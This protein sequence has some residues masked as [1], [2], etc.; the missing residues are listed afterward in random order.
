MSSCIT[1]VVQFHSLFQS[2]TN[3]GSDH[4]SL[5]TYN[6]EMLILSHIRFHAMAS[7]FPSTQRRPEFNALITLLSLRNGRQLEPELDS[8]SIGDHSPTM[9]FSNAIFQRPNLRSNSSSTSNHLKERFLDRL[10]EVISNRKGVEYVTCTVMTE[11]EDCVVVYASRNDGFDEKDR[12]F[13]DKFSAEMRKLFVGEHTVDEPGASLWTLLL[14]YYLPRLNH[15]NKELLTLALTIRALRQISSSINDKD[16]KELLD[17]FFNVVGHPS[18]T[19]KFHRLCYLALRLHATPSAQRLIQDQLGN[20]GSRLW[21]VIGFFARLQRAH[22]TFL[23][24][25]QILPTVKVVLI[26]QSDEVKPSN[27]ALPSL[28]STL[29]LIHQSLNSATVERYISRTYTVPGAQQMFD[30]RQSKSLHVH[31]ELQ[32]IRYLLQA[33]I[34]ID[35]IV[36]Y[37]GCSKRSCF[38]CKTFLVVFSGLR[39]RGCHGKLYNQWSIPEIQGIEEDTKETLERAVIRIQDILIQEIEK[40]L[41]TRNAVSESSAGTTAVSSSR[42]SVTSGS[43]GSPSESP[44]EDSEDSDTREEIAHQEN[45]Y[46]WEATPVASHQC[47]PVLANSGGTHNL[48]AGTGTHWLHHMGIAD[49]LLS[50]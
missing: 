18:S 28:S 1:A 37:M 16:L 48:I 50:R 43:P 34:P 33:H 5:H 47:L 42:A 41:S 9:G 10:A 35:E 8:P 3:L 29:Q 20:S 11:Y 40:P 17:S 25:A 12:I 21:R 31:A 13:C 7:R 23:E 15:Y 38:M 2:P 27:C 32:I 46:E 36:Q 6:N 44:I 22:R 24:I 26:P 30:H 39:T 14:E 19:L 4:Y 45:L 49:N